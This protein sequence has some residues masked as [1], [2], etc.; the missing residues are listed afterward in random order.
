MPGRTQEHD[1]FL[2][3]LDAMAHHVHEVV[4]ERERLVG[5]TWWGSGER[6][7]GQG[8]EPPPHLGL[9]PLPVLGDRVE[10]RKIGRIEVDLL[11]TAQPGAPAELDIELM[12]K[13]GSEV[14]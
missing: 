3:L 9:V 1:G 4:P 2:E 14:P 8:R 5:F 12:H 10:R 7:V 6:L 11:A 13:R